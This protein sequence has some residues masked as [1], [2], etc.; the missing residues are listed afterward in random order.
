MCNPNHTNQTLHNFFLLQGLWSTTRFFCCCCYSVVC[1]ID[2]FC[3]TISALWFYQ[4]F[5]FKVWQ[6]TRNM[7]KPI[8]DNDV[9]ERENTSMCNNASAC[10]T[11]RQF[12]SIDFINVMKICD[13]YDLT[14]RATERKLVRYDLNDEPCIF[15]LDYLF[16]ALL[17]IWLARKW[18]KISELISTRTQTP[19]S[20]HSFHSHFIYVACRNMESER[21]RKHW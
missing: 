18:R 4:P 3:M 21:E 19:V 9:T 17:C 13:V 14:V 10:N 12:R 2:P 15:D 6:H 7:V 11:T 20:L 16:L 8:S 5:K 1:S